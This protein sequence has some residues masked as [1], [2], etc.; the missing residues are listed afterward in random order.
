MD[1]ILEADDSLPTQTQG[2]NGG[3]PKKT[4][5]GDATLNST[6]EPSTEV[7]ADERHRNQKSAKMP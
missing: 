5:N 7:T 3:R 1:T 6:V 4:T 2:K